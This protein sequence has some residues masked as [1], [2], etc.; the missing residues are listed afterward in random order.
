MNV[1]IWPGVTIGEYTIVGAGTGVNNYILD[2][3]VAAGSPAK[4]VK[5]L[6][7]NE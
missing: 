5:Y 1:T 2:D 6:D 7:P 3:A 4:V